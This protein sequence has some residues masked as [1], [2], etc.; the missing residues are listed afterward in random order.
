MKSPA[1]KEIDRLADFIL[2]QFP[3]EP[4]SGGADESAVDVAIR[5]LKTLK[6]TEPEILDRL[7]DDAFKLSVRT[8]N[9]LRHGQILTVRDLISNRE[10]DLMMEKNCG[11]KTIV[12][13]RNVLSEKNLRLGMLPP[14]SGQ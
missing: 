5:L 7:V 3:D 9:V 2:T 13:L 8:S 12:E 6:V 14:I 1:D 11:R 4:G 10:R